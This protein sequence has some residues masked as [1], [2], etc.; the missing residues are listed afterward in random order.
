VDLGAI[1]LIVVMVLLLPA[2]LVGGGFLAAA[3][4]W[5]AKE[6]A[7]ATHEGSELIELNK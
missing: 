1:A 5:S 4:G 2:L 6:E 3:I 7:E